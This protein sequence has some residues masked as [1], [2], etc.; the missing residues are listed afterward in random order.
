MMKQNGCNI[1]DY[2]VCLYICLRYLIPLAIL[3]VFVFLCSC[4]MFFSTNVVTKKQCSSW[5]NFHLH[6]VLVHHSCI[7]FRLLI[8]S[9]IFTFISYFLLA[10]KFERN[11]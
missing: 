10:L 4:V 9:F 7:P 1:N 5:T 3:I 6:G 2:Y 8:M 11:I